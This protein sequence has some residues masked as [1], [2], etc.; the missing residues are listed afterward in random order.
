MLIASLECTC[1]V[2]GRQA[3]LLTVFQK[4]Y[5]R[6]LRTCRA[7]K[8]QEGEPQRDNRRT[9][10]V[11]GHVGTSAQGAEF[12]KKHELGKS[13]STDTEK[14]AKNQEPSTPKIG[15]SKQKSE[16]E[17]TTEEQPGTPE[18]GPRPSQL[19]TSAFKPMRLL[20][21]KE[22]HNSNQREQLNRLDIISYISQRLGEQH[23]IPVS[24]ISPRIK[25]RHKRP[26]QESPRSSKGGSKDEQGPSKRQKH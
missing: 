10:K 26:P 3:T 6:L 21:P 7:K 11:V 2:T 16:Q 13:S 5:P 22:Q 17:S 4:L 9:I 1:G 12:V 18:K 8:K 19:G 14:K 23:R 25:E 24:S 20:E 15:I